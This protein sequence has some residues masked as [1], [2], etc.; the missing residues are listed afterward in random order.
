MSPTGPNGGDFSAASRGYQLQK[1]AESEALIPAI[2]GKN[3]RKRAPHKSGNCGTDG[4]NS[5]DL[6]R[7]RRSFQWTKPFP[8]RNILTQWKKPRGRFWNYCCTLDLRPKKKNK[9]PN[10]E[11]APHSRGFFCGPILRID[12]QP[13]RSVPALCPSGN[14]PAPSYQRRI[15]ARAP[16]QCSREHQPH[17]RTDGG[18]NAWE[19]L[20]RDLCHRT[21]GDRFGCFRGKSSA[22]A[23]SVHFKLRLAIVGLSN[24][25]FGAAPLMMVG[26]TSGASPPKRVSLSS[27]WRLQT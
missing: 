13:D 24:A 15:T 3:S 1:V 11:K 12:R 9:T 17:K 19:D 4:G 23:R 25:L 26:S 21:A 8:S 22:C 27:R 16:P 2:S 5:A 20:R 18:E 6:S 14:T 10:K 7:S